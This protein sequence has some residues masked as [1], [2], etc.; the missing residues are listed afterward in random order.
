METKTT[1]LIAPIRKSPVL[2]SSTPFTVSPPSSLGLKLV[3][4]HIPGPHF[5]PPQIFTVGDLHHLAPCHRGR[6]GFTVC[7]L[8]SGASGPSTG[9]ASALWQQREEGERP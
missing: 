1:P 9:E 2:T 3:P 5:I 7:V 6:P 8:H 4:G